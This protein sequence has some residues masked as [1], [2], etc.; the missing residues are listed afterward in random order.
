[1]ALPTPRP[2][3]W[4]AL[5]T[6]SLRS[7]RNSA[8]HCDWPQGGGTSRSGPSRYCSAH[9]GLGTFSAA[10]PIAAV[11]QWARSPRPAAAG[12]TRRARLIAVGSPPEVLPDGAAFTVPIVDDPAASPRTRRH[13]SNAR[14]RGC[15]ALSSAA[16]RRLG[17]ARN[18]LGREAERADQHLDAARGCAEQHQH[19][20]QS[21]QGAV[22]GWS[23]QRDHQSAHCYDRSEHLD[24]RWS[25]QPGAAGGC[26][27]SGRRV[28]KG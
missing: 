10:S 23:R 14:L 9:A 2:R 15:Q 5:S 26:S 28:V 11:R 21:H 22:A 4:T 8:T 20:E 27:G 24:G 18:L 19:E 7:C 13:A 16:R 1:M 25:A 6:T 17:S 3:P 12:R